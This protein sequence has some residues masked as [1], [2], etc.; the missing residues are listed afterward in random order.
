MKSSIKKLGLLGLG[1]MMIHCAAQKPVVARE[2]RFGFDRDSLNPATRAALDQSAH[3][4]KNKPK[5]VVLLE[6]HTDAT[7]SEIYN[8]DLGDRR[9][10]SVRAYLVR[11]GV[12]PR[13][14]VTVTYG[15]SKSRDS[16]KPAPEKRRVLLRDVLVK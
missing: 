12:E 8:L 11:Q 10:R 4:L 13:R 3:E 1:L 9:A 2:V 7:G 6:G 15:E 5:T 14:L 16:R